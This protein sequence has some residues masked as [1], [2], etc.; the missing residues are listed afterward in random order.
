ML[1]ENQF[2]E[3]FVA[4]IDRFGV[5]AI[6]ILSDEPDAAVTVSARPSNGMLSPFIGSAPKRFDG[7]DDPVEFRVDHENVKRF[8]RSD[9]GADP[10]RRNIEPGAPRVSWFAAAAAVRRKCPASPRA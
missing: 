6:E 5:E 4:P 7:A 10:D 2:R 8:A 3:Y 1:G 9:F